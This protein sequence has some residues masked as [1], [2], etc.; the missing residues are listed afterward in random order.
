MTLLESC[1]APGNKTLQLQKYFAQNH[2]I[3][4]EK[5]AGRFAIF[6]SR[7]ERLRGS[8]FA[9]YELKNAN[10][11]RVGDLD[12]KTKDSVKIGV[13]DP[14]CSGSGMLDNFESREVTEAVTNESNQYSGKLHNE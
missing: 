14:S 6:K 13:C 1:S 11:F 5:D 8:D 10:F 4:Y 12:Q 3:S 7:V 9:S 2:V